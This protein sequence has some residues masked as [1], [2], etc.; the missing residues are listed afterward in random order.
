MNLSQRSVKRTAALLRLGNFLL[1]MFQQRSRMLLLLALA[2]RRRRSTPVCERERER[3]DGAVSWGV[4]ESD[5]VDIEC[6][7]CILT[8]TTEDYVE[9]NDTCNHSCP[10]RPHFLNC[11]NKCQ[12][13]VTN[14]PLEAIR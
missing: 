8:N 14:I 2:I 5:E 10:D 3:E 11:N 9:Q 7:E 4:G 12:F 1:K 6:S 13:C